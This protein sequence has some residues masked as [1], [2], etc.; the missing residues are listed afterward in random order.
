MA[1]RTNFY[2]NP[3]YS[4]NKH[5]NINSVIQNLR[6]YNVVIGNV[7][8]NEERVTGN[9]KTELRKR[10]RDRGQISPVQTE[11]IVERDGPMTHEDYIKKRREEINSGASYEQLTAD[12]LGNSASVSRIAEH[13]N[14]GDINKSDDC[15][16]KHDSGNPV[17]LCA[18]HVE[19]Q[20]CP[21]FG[22]ADTIDRVKSQFEQRF[23]SP[24][25]PICVVCGKYGEYI[26]NET[27]DDICSIDCKL[28]LLQNIKPQQGLSTASISTDSL[29]QEQGLLNLP[30]PV[31]D[32]WDYDLNCWSKRR[33]CL[34]T[35]KCWKCQRPGHLAEDCLVITPPHQDFSSHVTRNH[36]NHYKSRS[37]P[38]DLLE[39]YKRCHQIGKN[40]LGAKCIVCRRCTSLS[41]C[42]SCS[43]TYC[44]S[45]GHLGDHIRM[46]TSHRQYYSHKLKR[47]VKC[48]KSTC[49]VTG[50]KDLLAC[51]YCLNKAFDKFYD[52]YTATWK[53]AGLSII[54]GSICCEDHFEWH[55]MNCLSAEVEGSA[56]IFRNDDHAPLNDLIF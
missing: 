6:A 43:N 50:I 38:S 8:Q 28:E 30:E 27:D 20:T 40:T 34:S 1:N 45:A 42:L 55:R 17:E 52:M 19:N 18:T 47:L 4:Y 12:V 46:H 33:S 14:A 48:N 32:T 3:S 15:G 9:E 11:S 26:C 16:G 2:K 24:G 37:L 36:G 29:S 51:H 10:R 44:D 35:Y 31:D 23:P 49:K 25:E 53:E 22:N 41:T 5:L 13:G 56:R 7:P 21:T 39:L 54:W